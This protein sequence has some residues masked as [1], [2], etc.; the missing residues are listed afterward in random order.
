M[1]QHNKPLACTHADARGTHDTFFAQL[2]QVSGRHFPAYNSQSVYVK[3]QNQV[4]AVNACRPSS[5][6]GPSHSSRDPL[7]QRLRARRS[8][9]RSLQKSQTPAP[10][11][12]RGPA[13]RGAWSCSCHS[14]SCH[15]CSRP[16]QS[17]SFHPLRCPQ[18]QLLCA[19]FSSSSARL[20]QAPALRAHPVDRP[21]DPL[22]RSM[23]QV[24]V[25]GLK[26]CCDATMAKV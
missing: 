11:R 16:F 18:P 1:S 19:S 3:Q 7:L 9:T 10:H 2:T 26:L 23:L 25:N 5:W 12:P 20:R 21:L 15:S 17:N 24:I 22:H 4:S 8:S 13:H 6:T 14:C